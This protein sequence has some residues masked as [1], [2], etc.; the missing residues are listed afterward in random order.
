MAPFK[1]SW[2]PQNLLLILPFYSEDDIWPEIEKNVSFL[3][4]VKLKNWFVLPHIFFNFLLLVIA[5][6]FRLVKL[7][8]AWW[9]V[10]IFQS[11]FQRDLKTSS[12]STWGRSP[13]L[14]SSLAD[15]FTNYKVA[16]LIIIQLIKTFSKTP[17]IDVSWPKAAKSEIIWVTITKTKH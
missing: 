17:K 4:K 6:L 14:V 15:L 13:F 5:V 8:L 11:N 16:R 3:L 7:T 12:F 9:K 2:K 10:G 1:R